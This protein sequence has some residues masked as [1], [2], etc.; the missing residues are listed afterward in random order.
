MLE[1]CTARLRL[2][3]IT[4]LYF[5]IYFEEIPVGKIE[6]VLEDCLIDYN[7]YY[8]I[9]AQY[10]GNGFMTE[11]FIAFNNYFR[12][13]LKRNIYLHIHEQNNRSANVAIKSGFI[14]KGKVKYADGIHIVYKD[15]REPI[16]DN[17]AWENIQ[18]I[19]IPFKKI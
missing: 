6:A 15:S 3:S 14:P 10:Q 4:S 5:I 17:K 8:E 19:V 18:A 1:I 12:E 2:V 7:C 9:D 11:A 16:V 13:V